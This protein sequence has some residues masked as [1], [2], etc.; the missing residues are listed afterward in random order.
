MA[1]I[2]LTGAVEGDAEIRGNTDVGALTAPA[3][4]CTNSDA[5]ND[6]P[7]IPRERFI[8]HHPFV[9]RKVVLL[10]LNIDQVVY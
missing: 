6:G 5:P 10:L 9:A 4:G 2:L 8:V 7:K 3:P 1:A